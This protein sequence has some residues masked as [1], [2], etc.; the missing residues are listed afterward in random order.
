MSRYTKPVYKVDG[1][2][3]ST[4]DKDVAIERAKDLALIKE[5]PVRIYCNGEKCMT[6]GTEIYKIKNTSVK[7]FSLVEVIK[8]AKKLARATGEA[9][10]IILNNCPFKLMDRNGVIAGV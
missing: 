5:S 9:M 7:T 3:L 6:I 4:L 2:D 1:T 8:D 10:L